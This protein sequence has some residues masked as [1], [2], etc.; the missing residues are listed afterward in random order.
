MVLS[1]FRLYM[2]L[3][4]SLHIGATA[5]A[6]VDAQ[7]AATIYLTQNVVITTEDLNTVVESYRDLVR[8]QGGISPTVNPLDFLREMILSELVRQGAVRDGVSV[9]SDQVDQMVWSWRKNQVEPLLG[10]ALTDREFNEFVTVFYGGLE[11]LRANFEFQALLNAYVEKVRP[12]LLSMVDPVTDEEIDA[13]YRQNQRQFVNTENVKLSHI[14]IPYAKGEASD[15]RNTLNRD[16]MERLVHDIRT[17]ALTFEE[18]VLEYSEDDSSKDAGGAIGWLSMDNMTAR[19]RAGESFFN[20][21]FNVPVGSV[22]DVVNSNIGYHILKV[23]AHEDFK[24]LALD[25]PISPEASTT[26]REYISGYLLEWK[27]NQA[28]QRTAQAIIQ[29]L[30]DQATI[31]IFFEGAL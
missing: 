2:M 25:D 28:F 3:A 6:S 5:Y 12:D 13:F 22:S 17:G 9:S 30:R 19:N 15:A 14:F 10:Y 20:A 26:V 7:P 18:A 24:L 1:R 27:V 16:M 29:E 8:S 31:K 23:H 11:T 21:A 4:L